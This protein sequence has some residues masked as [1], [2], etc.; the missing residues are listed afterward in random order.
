MMNEML[1]KISCED[2]A[3]SIDSMMKDI[4]SKMMQNMDM[5]EMYPKCTKMMANKLPKERRVELIPKI[6]FSL[7]K[8]GTS[9]MSEEN[10]QIVINSIIDNL[11]QEVIK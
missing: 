1:K 3:Q 5:E 2:K 6:V 10:K 9:D 8:N 7:V 4:M 11:K